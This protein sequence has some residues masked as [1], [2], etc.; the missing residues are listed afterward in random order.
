MKKRLFWVILPIILL[1]TACV[2]KS[3]MD[4]WFTKEV[5]VH[6]PLPKMRQT[7]H[8]Q[9]LLTFNHEG[10][11]HSLITLVDIDDNKLTVVGLSALGI[12]LFKIEYNGT[13]IL[14][15]QNIFIKELP[16]A[17][18]ILS[19]IML[20]LIPIQEW[21]QVLPMNWKVIDQGLQR[22][23]LNDKH[24]TIIEINYNQPASNEI[25]KPILIKHHIFGY[26]IS[27]QSMESQ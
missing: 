23:L 5:K 1:L 20:S 15:E 9:Q 24:E 27:I 3:P 2:A 12:R 11:T 7:Y 18:Q 8:D 14:T 13:Q 26:Q 16:S 21:Q 6:L 10:Q 4:V 22:K 17:A 19:D 25:R